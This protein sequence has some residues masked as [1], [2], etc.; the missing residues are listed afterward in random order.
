[1]LLLLVRDHWVLVFAVTAVAGLL[2]GIYEAATRNR[3]DNGWIDLPQQG[4]TE[5][6]LADIDGRG[7]TSVQIRK[8]SGRVEKQRP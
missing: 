1:M 8:K 3:A 2:W 4:V 7:R 6:L 5:R